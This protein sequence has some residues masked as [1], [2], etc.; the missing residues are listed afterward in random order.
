MTATIAVRV[1]ALEWDRL[2]A[3]LDERGFAI[4]D[5]VLSPAECRGVAELFETGSFRSTI[6]MARHRFGDGRPSPMRGPSGCRA[7]GRASRRRT[8]SCS[9]A[10][11]LPDRNARRR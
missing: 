3:E 4:T 2:R 9:S 8:R 7:T 5:R 6:D 10:A 11:A 1:H